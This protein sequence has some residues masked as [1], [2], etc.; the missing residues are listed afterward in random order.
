MRDSRSALHASEYAIEAAA[1]GGFMLSACAF[2]VL[3][4]HPSSPVRALIAEPFF[5]R[6]LMG[7]AMGLTAIAIVYS[8]WGQRSGAHMN[9]SVTLTFWRLGRVPGRD[10]AGYV[11]AQIAGGIG[12]VL[13]ARALLGAAVAHP[14]VDFVVTRPGAHGPIVAFAAET[15]ITFVL[16]SVVLLMSNTPSIARWTGVACGLLVALYITLEAP[17]SG[18]SMNPARSLGSAAVAGDLGNLWIYLI[19]PPL[20]MLAAAEIYL[21]AFGEHGVFCAKLDH[22]SDRPCLFCAA[23][24]A[25]SLDPSRSHSWEPAATTNSPTT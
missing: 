13:V 2:G 8:P 18:M 9:P 3:L 10:A 25:A 20:G 22:P 23:R 24:A 11:T 1:L 19:A 4:E 7:V 6:A 12:G 17:L 21:R 5:R 14:S 16:M 15:A